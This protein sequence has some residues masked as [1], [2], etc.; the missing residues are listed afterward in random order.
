MVKATRKSS[1]LLCFPSPPRACGDGAMCPQSGQAPCWGGCCEHE[2]ARD[3]DARP[4]CSR[5]AHLQFRLAGAPRRVLGG[6]VCVGVGMRSA[7]RRSTDMVVQDDQKG[8]NLVFSTYDLESRD[9]MDFAHFCSAFETVQVQCVL[10][11]GRVLWRVTCS[12]GRSKTIRDCSSGSREVEAAVGG[13][14]AS[15]RLTCRCCTK[16][17][18]RR[19]LLSLYQGALT[20]SCLRVRSCCAW[21]QCCH[22]C[23]NVCGAPRNCYYINMAMRSTNSLRDTLPPPARPLRCHAPSS[24]RGA[25]RAQRLHMREA[26]THVLENV[27]YLALS[28]DPSPRQRR[29]NLRATWQAHKREKNEKT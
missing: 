14:V 20:G 7:F 27:L 10:A 25:P 9:R 5:D 6:A 23:T 2:A 13:Q 15:T 21:L 12:T 8:L 1:E 16:T 22:V 3:S 28:V 29:R 19:V 4:V 24:P 17:D 26:P 18:E 11:W